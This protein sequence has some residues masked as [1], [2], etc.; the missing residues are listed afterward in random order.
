MLDGTSCGG[1]LPSN[2]T[3]LFLRVT[4]FLDLSSWAG[5]FPQRL[6]LAVTVLGADWRRKTGISQG[7]IHKLLT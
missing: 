3:R 1:F 4:V 6:G 2:L 7:L 5:Q